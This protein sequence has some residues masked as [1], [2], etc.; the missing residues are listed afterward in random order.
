M[1]L[2]IY[3]L[4]FLHSYKAFYSL[5]KFL[6]SYKAFYP[7][8]RFLHSYKAFYLLSNRSKKIYFL[9]RFLSDSIVNGGYK[10]KELKFN[11]GRIKRYN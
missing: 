2:F 8:S 9:R 10:I 5:S 6:H 11:N 1:N 3:Y 4:T 7:L